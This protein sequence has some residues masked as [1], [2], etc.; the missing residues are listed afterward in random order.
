MPQVT[1]VVRVLKTPVT[2]IALL[3][4]TLVAGFF[5]LKAATAPVAKSSG[6]CVMTDV[7]NE[8][9]P[10]RVSVRLLNAGA[11]SGRAKEAAGYIRG[12]GFNVV[13]INNSD[14]EVT[15]TVIVGTAT[16]SP[17]VLLLKQVFPEALIEADGR[18]DHVV[19]ILIGTKTTRTPTR[20]SGVAVSGRICLPPGSANSTPSATTSASTDTPSPSASKKKKK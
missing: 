2:L 8:L 10:A 18:A 12:Y 3:A 17:E 19:D 20:P 16:D 4:F 15:D 6:N 1:Q 5:G 11:L 9:T 7:G 14:R 13:R